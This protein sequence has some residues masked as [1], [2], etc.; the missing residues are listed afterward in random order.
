MVQTVP[1]LP[2]IRFSV[3]G[4][5]FTSD[6]HGLAF[7][8]VSNPETYQLEVLQ[9][10]NSPPETRL[11]FATWSDGNRSVVRSVTVNS[12]TFLEAGFVVTREASVT[13]LDDR[14]QRIDP[15]RIESL[16]LTDDSGEVYTLPQGESRWIPVVRT[17]EVGE[18]LEEEDVRYSIGEAIVDG[19]DVSSQLPDALDPLDQK[20][21]EFSVK[22]PSSERSEG[23]ELNL[24]L[25][26][27]S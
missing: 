21:W 7:T 17:L 14:G 18:S 10:S 6:K 22:L 5:I 3:N 24:D 27:G 2:G 12:F 25:S 1:K 8:G 13:L 23:G 4:H 16:T 19:N 20:E 9:P 11:R 26:S 15:L